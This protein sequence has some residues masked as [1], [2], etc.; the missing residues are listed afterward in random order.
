MTDQVQPA[1][2]NHLIAE[3]RAK[4]GALRGQGIAFPNDFRRADYAGDLQD[5]FIDAD[6]WTGEA[7]DASGR[8][9][10]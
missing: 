6:T 4:L 1:D 10:A 7:L 2:E 8:R 9:V 3:R 5:E